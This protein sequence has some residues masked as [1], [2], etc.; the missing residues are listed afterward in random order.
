MVAREVARRHSQSIVPAGIDSAS[1]LPLG[2]KRRDCIE[3]RVKEL[4][5]D[6]PELQTL[7][8]ESLKTSTL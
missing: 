2:S 4:V 6:H 5:R 7:I 3:N 1:L 8:V